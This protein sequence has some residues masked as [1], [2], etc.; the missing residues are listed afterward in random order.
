MLF[1]GK[2]SFLF[3]CFLSKDCS[4]SIYVNVQHIES[5]ISIS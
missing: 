4:F 3:V 2:H 5:K 1:S